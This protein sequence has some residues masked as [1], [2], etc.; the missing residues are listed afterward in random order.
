AHGE[1]V[2]PE[3]EV[4]QMPRTGTPITHRVLALMSG[5]PIGA[6]GWTGGSVLSISERMLNA[7]VSR[8]LVD[9]RKVRCTVQRVDTVEKS[10]FPLS[11]V[12]QNALDFVY[13]VEPLGT[14]QDP[15]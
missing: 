12:T 3:L 7:W 6:V 9:S 8:L 2:P 10:A 15:S 1:G 5:T 13:G 4:A 11:E 14:G